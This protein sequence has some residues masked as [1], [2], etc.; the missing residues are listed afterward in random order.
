MRIVILGASGNA[1]RE[2]ARLLA[3][4]LTADD[5]LVLA[6]RNKNRLA[7]TATLCS[8]P[9]QVEIKVVDATDDAAVR[10]LVTGASIVVVTVSLPER[11]PALARIVAQAGADWYDTLLSSKE[12]LSALRDLE[13]EIRSAGLR[14]I[15][16]GGFHPGLPAAMVR[17]AARRIDNLESAVV[18][19]GMRI[20]WRADTLSDSTIEEM[21]TEFADFDLSTFV[22]GE[23]RKLKWSECPKVDFGP[24]IGRKS[25]LPMYLSEM[26]P[27]PTEISSLQRCGFFICGFS[28]LL[29]Y[30]ALPV[31][32]GMAKIPKLRKAAINFTRWSFGHLASAAP[33]HKLLVRLEASGLNAGQPAKARLEI[34]GDDGYLV[35][36]APVVVGI[37]RLMTGES[38]EPGLWLQ[39]QF[40]D[41]DDLPADLA[42]LG[43]TVDSSVTPPEPPRTA[44]SN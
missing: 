27:L 24:P 23:W 10:E 11:V 12:K 16:D 34:S 15:T 25:C 38:R 29:D 39:A 5:E 28:P 37:H 20:D 3:P 43:V 1:G 30:L 42:S 36:A 21:F 26:D 9:C 22:A 32:M 31:I 19:A 40:I 14:F 7:D 2:I 35:T 6:A 8:G 33:P 41:S 17:W 4:G 44:G 13:P 18:Y